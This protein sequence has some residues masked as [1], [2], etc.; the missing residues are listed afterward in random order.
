MCSIVYSRTSLILAVTDIHKV[1]ANLSEC[2]LATAALLAALA[3]STSFFK[4]TISCI[5]NTNKY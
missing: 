4:A 3:S 5:L 2:A 1:S